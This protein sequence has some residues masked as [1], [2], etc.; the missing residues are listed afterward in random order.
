MT[1]L[2]LLRQELKGKVSEAAP[3]AGFSERNLS[4]YLNDK[5]VQA[6]PLGCLRNLYNA[7]FIS[8][9]TFETAKQERIDEIIRCK[10]ERRKEKPRVV[11]RSLRKIFAIPF[12]RN[13]A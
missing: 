10:R 3:I 12:Y 1:S 8:E 4:R 13:P 7:G 6:L 2:V 9:E 11:K 5:M